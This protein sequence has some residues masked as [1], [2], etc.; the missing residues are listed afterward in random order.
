MSVDDPDPVAD[1]I[2]LGLCYRHGRG[3]FADYFAALA[4]GRALASRDPD[5]GRVSF[6]PAPE[7]GRHERV[8]LPGTGTVAAITRGPALLPL[9][10]APLEA[11]FALIAMD[12][13]DNL[14]FGRIEGDA[15][16]A[17]GAR[18]RLAPS[19]GAVHHPAQ[20][21]CFVPVED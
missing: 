9:H 21:V 20:A 7:P 17:P 19:S 18:M 6:P 2:R 4:E 8:A 5:T 3:G 1:L 15:P 13:A 10:P 16:L 12:G 14:C 11:C